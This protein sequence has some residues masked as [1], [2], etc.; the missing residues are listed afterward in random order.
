MTV[1][2]LLL[3][4]SG[5]DDSA[6]ARRAAIDLCAASGMP[7]HLGLVWDVPAYPGSLPVAMYRE[8]AARRLETEV[9]T[10]TSLGAEVG[11]AHLVRARRPDGILTL[12]D[13]LAAGMIVTGRQARGR[14]QR[15]FIDSISDAVSRRSVIPVM[16]VPAEAAVWPPRRV[17]IGD[18]GS[19]D[20]PAVVVTGGT[21]AGVLG[22]P[23]T[24]VHAHPR[25][26][27]PAEH[28]TEVRAHARWLTAETGRRTH[29]VRLDGDPAEVLLQVGGDHRGALLVVGR[30]W[31]GR[32][33][34]R[35]ERV[36]TRI[37]AHGGAACVMV[38]R[39]PARVR[40]RTPPRAPYAAA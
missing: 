3:A 36:S 13:R 4:T 2:P 28:A 39:T 21:I 29:V 25:G 11:G 35:G 23:V 16:V 27:M 20:S 10:V 14:L 22:L 37:L 5:L 24:L 9:R 40:V 17:V 12:A 32:V 30:R 1:H 18:D 38:P 8:E 31:P 6:V 15:L 34:A 7:L 19:A 33:D 26:D